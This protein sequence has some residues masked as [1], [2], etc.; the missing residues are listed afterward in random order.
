MIYN[1]HTEE[2]FRKAIILFYFFAFLFLAICIYLIAILTAGIINNGC[3]SRIVTIYKCHTAEL[4]FQYFTPTAHVISIV[5]CQYIVP[6]DKQIVVISGSCATVVNSWHAL[7][8]A[9]IVSAGSAKKIVSISN[10]LSSLS[11]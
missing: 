2:I 6:P 1:L 11:W 8:I 5:H 10:K 3:H 7:Q 4:P 9:K